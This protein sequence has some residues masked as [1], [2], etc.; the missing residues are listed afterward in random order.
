MA[1]ASTDNPLFEIG[2]VPSTGDVQFLERLGEGMG[3]GRFKAVLGDAGGAVV[4][5]LMAPPEK[6]ARAE[7]EAWAR[8]M[9]TLEHPSTPGVERIEEVLEPQFVAFEFVDG[10]SLAVRLADDGAL[11]PLDAIVMCLQ[12]AAGIR[13]AHE[14][15]LAH[16]AIS[17]SSIV[18]SP[19]S[20]APDV[21]RLVG[22]IPIDES[23]L[24]AAQRRDLCGLG[25]VL[26][27]AMT[28]GGARETGR[29]ERVTGVPT[30]LADLLEP[31]ADGD[32]A[33][34]FDEI[35]MDWA[36]VGHGDLHGLG[37]IAQHAQEGG[38]E[39]V[40]DLID[41][42]VAPL[43]LRL[44]EVYEDVGQRAA[45]D[46]AFLDEVERYRA[47]E[48]SLESKLRW[49]RGWLHERAARIDA[50][51]RSVDLHGADERLH[52][53]VEMELSLLLGRSLPPSEAVIPEPQVQAIEGVPTSEID[54]FDDL[55][56]VGAGVALPRSARTPEPMAPLEPDTDPTP[57]DPE[58]ATPARP[59]E[60][61]PPARVAEP[62]SADAPVD[63]G[64]PLPPPRPLRTAPT[65]IEPERGR[66]GGL[67]T[68]LGLIFAA[69]VVGVAVTWFALP[70][71]ELGV[72]EATPEAPA[73]A[74]ATSAEPL[75]APPVFP[76]P[77][78]DEQV[79]PAT[80]E[81]DAPAPAAVKPAPEP[82]LEPEP[83]VEP[84]VEVPSVR[85]GLGPDQLGA[86][87]AQCS[88][89]LAKHQ[90]EKACT[91]ARFADEALGQPVAVGAFF[92]DRD[93]VT[94][95]AYR[96][97]RTC[98]APRLTWEMGEQP[99][100]GVTLADAKAYCEAQ[101]KRLPTWF[102]WL[103]AARGNDLRLYPWGDAPP[104]E[105][106]KHRANFG[107]MGRRKLLVDREDGHYYA[108]PVG[109]FAS[110][111]ASPFG[112]ANMA[113]NV[114]EWTSTEA[115]ERRVWVA[116]GSWRG[117]A[118]DVRVT[119]RE[120]VDPATHANDLGVRCARDVDVK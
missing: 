55:A 115:G 11:D 103:H 27:L 4:S 30:P 50:A 25:R 24:Q 76:R 117:L 75:P 107:K 63:P 119:R 5:L 86:A 72:E 109:A 37:G 41:A 48:R 2:P 6:E 34:T 66:S 26:H 106:G 108:A 57:L 13:A 3:A 65:R 101:G 7:L 111:A 62:V 8:R 69:I 9:R 114:R 97:C 67:K 64:P 12:A 49:V 38:Y 56:R 91:A 99:T 21:A 96:R 14:V 77:R 70:T 104:V 68:L 112:L 78:I 93:E 82:E 81:L 44:D 120:A 17:T 59:A 61:A 33:G 32:P 28:G 116:G 35:L 118:H 10:V 73:A 98:V 15:G 80:A 31:E 40:D 94:Q 51:S 53:N 20:G 95:A 87:M 18:L 105:G 60:S 110:R 85:P 19:R 113:G 16:G 22:W 89:D 45:R 46:R 47:Q 29:A 88:E 1:Q 84:A 23:D 39:R 74:R 71:P 52:R 36:E 83:A 54:P 92:L 90:P 58:S 42:L 102:E 100:V 79:P 43:R